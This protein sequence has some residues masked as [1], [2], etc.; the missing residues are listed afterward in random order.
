MMA[1]TPRGEPMRIVIGLGGVAIFIG[2][3]F[4]RIGGTRA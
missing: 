2:G 1:F 3:L 4:A